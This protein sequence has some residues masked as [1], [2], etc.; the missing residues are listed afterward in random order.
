M[1]PASL[2]LLFQPLLFVGGILIYCR[3]HPVRCG[4][5]RRATEL[6]QRFPDAEQISEVVSL[7]SNWSA[8]KQRELEARIAQMQDQGW[9]Y[10][11]TTAV[12][13]LVS[14]RHW[15]GAVRLHFILP[16]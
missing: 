16:R 7:C 15:G 14:L 11:R 4:M 3:C 10:L 9:I 1:I 5:E 6:T 2:F 12:S 13:P 8:G